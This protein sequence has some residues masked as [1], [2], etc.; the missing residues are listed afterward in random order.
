MPV[1]NTDEPTPFRVCP[2]AEVLY[3]GTDSYAPGGGQIVHWQWDWEGDGTI[4]FEGD[5]GWASHAYT[6]PGIYRLQLHVIDDQDCESIELTNYIVQVS[7]D[8]EW[9]MDPL[10]YTT[11]TNNPVE[12]SVG[13]EG[14][15]YTL[16]PTVDFGGGLFIPDEP[17]Q[18]F[19]SDL[20]FTQFIP[21]QT[22]GDGNDALESFFIEFEHSYMGDLTIRFICPNGQS[23]MVH[24]QGGG[25][26]FLGIPVDND[27]DPNTPGTGFPTPPTAP[28][29]TTLGARCRQAPTKACKRGT[30]STGARSTACGK[31]K[32]ATCG[33]PTTALCS[34][35]PS[36]LPTAFTR[37]N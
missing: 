14:Q 31:W 28:G 25:G 29:Q 19:T 2:G 15:T 35:G 22:V 9:T 1:I 20:T 30:T 26:T 16:E 33:A 18:C 10:S 17:G 36:R 6:E 24:Q 12:L 4:D 5:S 23:V 8:P 27:G 3:D 21:G 11:C 34:I 37:K 13:I 7:T 32:F